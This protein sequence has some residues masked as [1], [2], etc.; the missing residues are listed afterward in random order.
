MAGVTLDSFD[1]LVDDEL[2]TAFDEVRG[3]T[4]KSLSLQFG[5]DGDTA[6]DAIHR[7]LARFLRDTPAEDIFRLGAT[8][9]G[10][11]RCA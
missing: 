3:A 1:P 6:L 9:A 11:G 7:A 5:V 4:M 8:R 2:M 10:A